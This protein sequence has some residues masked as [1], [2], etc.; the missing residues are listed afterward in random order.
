MFN[1]YAML[2]L[3]ISRKQ[4]SPTFFFKLHI[5]QIIFKQD[6]KEHNL[7]ILSVCRSQND[8]EVFAES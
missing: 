1:K 4:K 3:A 2:A 6:S 5:Q 8:I 7:D